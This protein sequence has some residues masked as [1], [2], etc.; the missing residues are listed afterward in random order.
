[1]K[2]TTG[3]GVVECP[4]FF[5][6]RLR[7]LFL[8]MHK[9]GGTT[10]LCGNL[11][12]HHLALVPSFVVHLLKNV[13]YIKPTCWSWLGKHANTNH[14]RSEAVKQDHP[15]ILEKKVD[16]QELGREQPHILER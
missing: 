3:G 1:M 8:Y 15:C 12:Q 16:V 5:Y 13:D 9:V 2:L 14:C 10:K 11:Q 7:I 4:R 6:R